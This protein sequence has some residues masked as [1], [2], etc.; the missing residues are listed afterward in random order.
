ML[1]PLW[2]VSFEFFAGCGGE[3]AQE[4]ALFVG[5]FARH[6]HFDDD[7]LVALAAPVDVG[8]AFAAQGIDLAGLC[9]FVEFQFFLAAENGNLD[10]AAQRGAGEGDGD[11]AVDVVALP[12]ERVVFAHI[13][14]DI[15]V[16]RRTAALARIAFAHDAQAQARLGSRRNFHG[17]LAHFAD[18]P[19]AVA[20]LAGGGDDFARAPAF[21]AG[22]AAVERAEQG[23]L[24][25]ANLALTV[26]LRAGFGRRAGLCAV[27]VAGFAHL[28][29]RILHGLFHAGRHLFQRQFHVF[30]QIVAARYGG[31]AALLPPLCCP[32]TMSKIRRTEPRHRRIRRSRRRLRR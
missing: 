15:Q 27:P 12:L 22:L 20:R 4:F 9:P 31:A 10:G 8:Q 2:W 30:A 14:H 5:Q 26:T 23:V 3:L 13:D 21:R 7:V 6:F 1:G 24:R 18:A 17:A 16:A 19:A 29:A 11:F 28:H 25:K 32:K